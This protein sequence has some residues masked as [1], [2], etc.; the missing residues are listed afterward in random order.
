MGV[1]PNDNGLFPVA[2]ETGDARDDDGLAED[3]AAE[4]VTDGCV[5]TWLV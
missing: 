1:A 4:N 5:V 3:G 2:D